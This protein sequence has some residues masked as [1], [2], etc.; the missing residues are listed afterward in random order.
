MKEKL[1]DRSI[2]P[3]GPSLGIE[4]LPMRGPSKVWIRSL[5]AHTN[6]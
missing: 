5:A 4:L 1:D 3:D 2:E 6:L